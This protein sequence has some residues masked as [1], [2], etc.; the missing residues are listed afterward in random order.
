M[1]RRLMGKREERFGVA[2]ERKQ[3]ER[4]HRHRPLQQRPRPPGIVRAEVLLVFE[5][6][7]LPERPPP[8]LR[9]HQKR[10]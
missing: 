5:L 7:G 8:H 1:H 10:E 9:H 2:A 3:R 6:R 4:Q